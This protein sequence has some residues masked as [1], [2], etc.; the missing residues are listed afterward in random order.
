MHDQ[1]MQVIF[2]QKYESDSYKDEII[3]SLDYINHEG[4][5]KIIGEKTVK[6]LK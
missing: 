2:R 5:W 3:K 6:V 1:I 4:N